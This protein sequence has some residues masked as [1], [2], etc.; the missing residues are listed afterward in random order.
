LQRFCLLII[1]SHK[2]IALCNLRILLVYPPT[3]DF[4][5][6]F[7]GCLKAGMI[8]VP[9]YPPDPKRLNKDL[10]MFAS[11]A[12]SCSATAALTSSQ[13]DYAAKLGS[14]KSVFSNISSGDDSSSWPQNLNWIVTDR[15]F[16]SVKSPLAS[17]VSS[18]SHS[19]CD[20]AFMQYTSG[21]TSDPKGV[22]I[23]HQNLSDN[24]RL[25]V[26][27]LNARDDT[28][29]VSWLPQYHDMGLIGS[30]LGALYSGGCGY[31]LSPLAF[32]RNPTLWVQAMSKYKATHIQAPNFAYALTARK[33]LA[34]A[35]NRVLKKD[36]TVLDLTSVRHMINAGIGIALATCV[37][38]A[39]CYCTSLRYLLYEVG[40]VRLSFSFS[41]SLC[42]SP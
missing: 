12:H 19:Q 20:I 9:T 28:V 40:K 1:Q 18:T 29:V 16:T 30:Y 35:R 14:L 22:I 37:L 24:L 38:C 33:H 10:K 6:A 36:S 32:I 2:K 41:L 8:A 7:L 3:L 15:F 13:Y 25:I 21:S 26:N 11:I 31:Y 27:G 23:T 42:L 17:C 5:V 34:Q 4:I 39:M